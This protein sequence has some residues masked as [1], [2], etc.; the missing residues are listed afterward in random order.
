MKKNYLFFIGL[1]F[2]SQ[3]ILYSQTLWEDDFETYEEGIF[4]G[5][6]GW[7]RDGG[8][9]NWVQ[10]ISLDE[11]YGKSMQL[12]TP[13]ENYAGIF[14]THY[15][16]WESRETGNDILEVSFDFYTGQEVSEGLGMIV[17]A[18]DDFD[19]VLS[20]AMASEENVIAIFAENLDEALVTN[21]DPNSWYHITLTYNAT[22]GEI[23]AQV[24]DE[25]VIEG[26]GVAGL[27][28]NV[29]DFTSII[30]SNIGLDNV[31]VTATN[32]SIL[33]VPEINEAVALQVF[34]NPV[35]SE[36]HLK[37]TKPIERTLVYDLSGKIVKEFA[38]Q[39]QFNLSDLSSG[40]YI[41]KVFFAEGYTK[42]Q[43]ILKK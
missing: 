9:D 11:G 12:N 27:E 30:E 17:I 18:T 40:E 15:N 24:N 34:P 21:P 6:N 4:M 39:N 22:N 29:F 43:K 37:S 31:S 16:D 10:I 42:T 2:I 35:I 23:K 26:S 32:E 41:L 20:V 3:A 19:E 28:P 7:I 38:E 25:P 5:E 33:A 1:F 36:V 8:E 13:D 14:V